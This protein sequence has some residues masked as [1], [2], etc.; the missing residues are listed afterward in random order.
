M[1]FAGV[2][3]LVFPQLKISQKPT[4]LFGG[5]E[6]GVGGPPREEILIPTRWVRTFVCL[7]LEVS[8]GDSFKVSKKKVLSCNSLKQSFHS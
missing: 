3:S 5:P 2:G 4:G 1:S 7:R 8:Y 6:G